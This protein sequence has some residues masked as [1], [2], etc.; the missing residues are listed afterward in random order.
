MSR[1]KRKEKKEKDDKVKLH[2]FIAT[3]A[4]DGRV[5][6]DFAISIAETAQ[7]A[8]LYGINITATI[9]G[10]GAFID[11]ARNRFVR[12]FLESKATHLFFI[13]ADLK[14][15]P[16][17]FVSLMMAGRPVCAGVYPKRQDPE[18]FPVRLWPHKDGGLWVEDNGWVMCDRV[19]TGFLC[20]ER[21]VVEE[22]AAKAK[23]IK[24]QKGEPD[25]PRLFYTYINEND[26]FVGEDFA[27]C[28]DYIKQYDR[29]IPVWPDFDFTH[30]VRWPGNWHTFLSKRIEEEEKQSAQMS[31]AA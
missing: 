29:P 22:M 13:D 30:G 19:P 9:M 21:K 6:T 2:A 4:Y 24:G 31:V 25:V 7:V 18:E 15:E 17:A 3:P 8:T 23:I 5:L 28:E 14:W 20:I 10:N 1:L 27:W 26:A 11:L 16:R 12:M